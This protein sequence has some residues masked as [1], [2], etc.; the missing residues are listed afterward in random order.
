MIQMMGNR[1]E[2]NYEGIY[3]IFEYILDNS[4]Y[5]KV[6]YE[7]D[8][9]Q[10]ISNEVKD[11]ELKP[12]YSPDDIGEDSCRDMKEMIDRIRATSEADVLENLNNYHIEYLV[13]VYKLHPGYKQLELYLK[14]QGGI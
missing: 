9:I 10:I 5:Y 6:V 1:Y 2:S 14:L 13:D 11:I 8:D 4:I 7:E 12:I 3:F